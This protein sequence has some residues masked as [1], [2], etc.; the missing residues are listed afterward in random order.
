MCTIRDLHVGYLEKLFLN[1]LICGYN[2]QPGYI[3]MSP[4][5]PL[6]YEDTICSWVHRVSS[7]I[8]TGLTRC[9]ASG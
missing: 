6:L 4:Y 5:S 3:E 2:L 9:L 1:V 8:F 7:K